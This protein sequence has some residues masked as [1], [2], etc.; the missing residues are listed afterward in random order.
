MMRPVDI[1]GSV[2]PVAAAAYLR[3]HGWALTREG[4]LGN[5]WQYRRDSLVRNVALPHPDLDELDRCLM[6]SSALRVIEE[7]EQRPATDITRDWRDGDSD[8]VSFRLVAPELVDGEIPLLAA[9][10]MLGGA[11]EAIQSA[12]R[13]EVAPRPSYGGQLPSEVRTF[14]DGAVVTPAEKGSVILNVRSKV[15]ASALAQMSFV[16]EA[17]RPRDGVPFE[18]RALRRLLSGVRAAKTAVHRD[19]T[20]AVDLD[21]F[22]SDIDDGL[23]ANLCD[24]LGRLAGDTRELGARVEV[25]VR[26]SLFVPSDEPKT[27]VEVGRSELDAL[28]TVADTLRN[29]QPLENVTLSGYVRN[30]DRNPGFSDGNVRLL[31]EIDGRLAVVR[32]H[33]DATDYE[34]AIQAHTRNTELRFTGTLEKAGKIWEVSQPR[35]ISLA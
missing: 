20:R 23:S 27:V 12:G 1:L 26:W 5:R 22:D 16:S 32:L 10:D 35:E 15:D 19:L 24:A 4:E 7:V 9:P 14:L 2:D 3:L 18:R 25:G 21:A 29:I 28:P 33:L 6:L 11:L 8:L 30:L 31:V 17:D 34:R 13:A